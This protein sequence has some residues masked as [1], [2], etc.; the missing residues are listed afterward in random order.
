M[1]CIGYVIIAKEYMKCTEGMQKNARRIT[2]MISGVK[3]HVL[4]KGLIEVVRDSLCESEEARENRNFLVFDVLRRHGFEFGVSPQISKRMPCVQTILR[5]ARTVQNT[6]GLH[7]PRRVVEEAR[8][9]KEER[10]RE[11][12]GEIAKKRGGE[13]C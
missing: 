9:R 5:H 8:Q 2:K 4:E 3:H 1:K 6:M 11:H 7:K 13:V 10:F 12:Y